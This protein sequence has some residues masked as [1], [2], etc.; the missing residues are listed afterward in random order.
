MTDRS[1]AYSDLWTIYRASNRYKDQILHWLDLP[2]TLPILSWKTQLEV[3]DNCPEEIIKKHQGLLKP[4]A[5][6]KLGLAVRNKK[7]TDSLW[8]ALS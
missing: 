6:K 7:F 8:T 2:K 1:M 4:E 5:M 3:L